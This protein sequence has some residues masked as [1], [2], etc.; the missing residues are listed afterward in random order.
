MKTQW[1]ENILEHYET[2]SSG[3]TVLDV[4]NDIESGLFQDIAGE[5]LSQDLIENVISFMLKMKII[6]GHQFDGYYKENS[7]WP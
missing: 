6:T 7:K 4:R 1:L 5:Y 2:A 3:S